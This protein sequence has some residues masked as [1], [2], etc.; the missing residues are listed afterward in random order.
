MSTG[1]VNT[2]FGLT[3]KYCPVTE[4]EETLRETFHTN[5]SIKEWL[6]GSY[7]QVDFHTYSDV[8]QRLQGNLD[9]LD[10][11]LAKIQLL[12]SPNI[13]TKAL[14]STA[15]VAMRTH[16]RIMHTVQASARLLDTDVGTTRVR[17]H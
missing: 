15:T 16:K 14:L 1:S 8:L 4:L 17:K 10:K 13:K 11:L 7:E 2:T 5:R 3:P 6:T 9:N 12:E